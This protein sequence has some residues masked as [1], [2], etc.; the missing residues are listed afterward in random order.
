MKLRKALQQKNKAVG[1]IAKKLQLIQ[2]HNVYVER[3]D[4]QVP[5]DTNKLLSDYMSDIRN[6][7]KLKADIAVANT[8]IQHK[9]HL[10]TELKYL[11]KN[12]Q[13][14]N[15]NENLNQQ[16]GRNDQIIVTKSVAQIK[17]VEI[18]NKIKDL[19]NEISN[20]QD[21]IDSFNATQEI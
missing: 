11:I 5:Y 4:L 19:E 3:P 13:T 8:Q 12:L 17:E 21:D 10:I 18:N 15:V 6:L 7:A 2:K 9:I 16:Y 1:D 20:L 14:I